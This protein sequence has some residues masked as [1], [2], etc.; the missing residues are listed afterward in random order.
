MAHIPTYQCYD[1]KNIS[2]TNLPQSSLLSPTNIPPS[3]PSSS[4]RK[5]PL[6]PSC[7]LAES[8][9]R[10]KHRKTSLSL[11]E[12]VAKVNDLLCE[13]KLSWMDLIPCFSTLREK[14]ALVNGLLLKLGLK[15]VD[16]IPRLRLLM[17]EKLG[18]VHDCIGAI[19]LTWN[20]V[21]YQMYTVPSPKEK[22]A[23]SPLDRSRFKSCSTT[24]STF[25]W[26]TT[27][28]SVGQI[29][30]RW[31]CH[32]YGRPDRDSR[33]M[34]S[35]MGERPY[36]E[37]CPVRPAL[38]SF[39]VQI[40]MRELV[41]R[42]EKAIHPS[43]GLHVYIPS[44]KQPT[45]QHVNVI[46][47]KNLGSQTLRKISAIHQRQQP[48]LRYILSRVASRQPSTGRD[49][50][51]DSSKQRPIAMVVDD[52][53]SKLAFSRSRM[54]RLGPFLT[55]LFHFS[56]NASNDT[57]CYKSRVGN[58]PAYTTILRGLHGLASQ[59][60]V[61]TRER[62][63]DLTRLVR[64]VVPESLDHPYIGDNHLPPTSREISGP[65]WLL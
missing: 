10:R 11:T 38:T 47:W 41:V 2:P 59:A 29:L 58:T 9:S 19:G 23:W 28:F 57:F 54:A 46:D 65:P 31:I 52:T 40:V 51:E 21:K 48:L 42:A 25:L 36:M 30:K 37:I 44:K 35:P 8:P 6:P 32:P 43:A 61:L 34:F 56:S 64:K 1:I 60:A 26:G 63:R 18:M 33:E 16:L 49:I 27:N 12:K 39:A 3:H 24:I 55:G 22:A 53:V 7:S 45:K 62:C 14:V 4:K 5:A 17:E 50:T 13:L 20:H 15:W